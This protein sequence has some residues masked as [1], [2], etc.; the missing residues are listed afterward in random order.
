MPRLICSPVCQKIRTKQRWQEKYDALYS[1]PERLKAHREQRREFWQHHPEK[2]VLRQ[3]RLNIRKRERRL[4]A[5]A[6][7]ESGLLLMEDAA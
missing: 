3:Q 6:V 7:R 1:D 5:R 2:R 4:I